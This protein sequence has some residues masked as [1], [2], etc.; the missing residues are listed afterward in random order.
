MLK[1]RLSLPRLRGALVKRLSK[2]NIRDKAPPTTTCAVTPQ[3]LCSL[4]V[5]VWQTIFEA[6][7]EGTPH[8]HDR[9]RRLGTLRLVSRAWNTLILDDNALWTTIIVDVRP[10]Q[11]LVVWLARS[12]SLKIDVVICLSETSDTKKHNAV[13]I[14][15]QLTNHM[16]TLLAFA[17]RWRTLTVYV[18][19]AT[20][21]LA[22]HVIST[23]PEGLA[24]EALNIRRTDEESTVVI[25][26][27]HLLDRLDG[28]SIRT[29]RMGGVNFGDW[30]K[31]PLETLTRLDF[32]A[33][34][35]EMSFLKLISVVHRLQRIEYLSIGKVSIP[36]EYM[37]RDTLQVGVLHDL[38][39]FRIDVGS[40]T[41]RDIQMI[42][43]YVKMPCL[44]TLILDG[45][46]SYGLKNFIQC[47][48]GPKTGKS[49]INVRH[50]STSLVSQIDSE[51]A[52]TFP[53]LQKLHLAW[54]M[55]NNDVPIYSV[56]TF[57]ALCQATP[58]LR[59]LVLFNAATTHWMRSL[60]DCI[61]IRNAPETGPEP[62]LERWSH[63]YS[64]TLGGT[65]LPEGPSESFLLLAHARLHDN[66]P[67]K[68][69]Y[70]DRR[71]LNSAPRVSLE[72]I[73][74]CG[75]VITAYDQKEMTTLG[76]ADW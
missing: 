41:R 60:Y 31:L 14:K 35:L 25:L 21:F 72:E 4:P 57:P 58:E 27:S 59:E 2:S 68:R 63:L 69:I 8:A 62:G 45:L 55:P 19:N 36:S 43:G 48:R 67:L 52:I 34:A 53:H 11:N 38:R 15:S 23:L 24:L 50:R 20:C 42:F 13:N 39:L 61:C 12:G 40:S 76:D 26:N 75:I 47:C 70:V 18:S 17:S 5:E 3:S 46:T 54:G 37:H 49:T 44:E 6:L 56:W 32:T 29:L 7:I 74:D 64:I 16:T 30:N 66:R 65:S 71:W 33:K 1:N 10:C 9:V 22:D 73:E 28:Y 51:Y